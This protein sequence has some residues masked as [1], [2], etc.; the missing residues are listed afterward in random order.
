MTSGPG[1]AVLA[2]I[3]FLWSVVLSTTASAQPG[4][5]SAPQTETCVACHLE[6]GDDRLVKPAQ[7]YAQDVHHAKGFGC[8]ACHGGDGKAEGMEAMDPAKG[9]IAKPGRRQISQVCGRCHA[10]ARF[11]KRYNPALRVDQVTE[12]ATSVHGRRLRE[13]NNPKV[14]VCTSCHPAH[15]IRP[16]S[17]PASSV[18]PLKVAETCARCHADAAYMAEYKLPTDQLQKY[19]HSVHW[20]TMSVKGDLAAPTCNSCH[21]NHGAAPPGVSWVGNV[22]GQCHA[23]MAD[24]FA[25]SVHAR[26]FSDLGAPGCATCHGNH[27]IQPTSVEMIGLG[28]KS[29][30]AA[31]HARDDKGGRAASDMRGLIDKLHLE[32]AGATALLERAERAGIE[33]S[34]ARFE[35]NAATDA[36]VKA[37]SAV[38][39][40]SVEAVQK[41]ADKAR[42][43]GA[44]ALDELQFRRRG[45][46]VSLVIILALIAGLVLKIRQLERRPPT[47]VAD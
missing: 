34:Q 9:Y 12:Y 43:R 24:L 11:M 33:V 32:H 36:L 17:D 10:D 29:V 30:C 23:V 7:A 2:A 13:L 4:Q 42:A 5:K 19:T 40:F 20:R 44:H 22:C 1:G 41:E 8:V 47:R 27:D 6:I 46:G 26:V 28:E 37:R 31:C 25:R 35:L 14:A 18:H 21:G 38:H 45:L 3:F 39:A 15:A 16:R